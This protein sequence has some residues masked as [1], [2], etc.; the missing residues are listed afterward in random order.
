[1]NI[2]IARTA[3]L[4]ALLSLPLAASAAALSGEAAKAAVA[5]AAGGAARNLSELKRFPIEF[6]AVTVGL[7]YGSEKGIPVG[8]NDTID[9]I[10]AMLRGKAA[11]WQSVTDACQTAKAEVDRA[12]SEL[13]TDEIGLLTSMSKESVALGRALRALESVRADIAKDIVL[14]DDLT[15]DDAARREARE[16]NKSILARKTAVFRELQSLTPAP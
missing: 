9:D 16:N 2:L 13:R 5:A 3:V 4:A 10:K 6:V 14:V 8:T 12:I 7:P 1:M 11:Y 15:S